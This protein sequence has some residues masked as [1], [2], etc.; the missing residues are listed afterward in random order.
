[1]HHYNAEA[2][3]ECF[4]MLDGRKA[5]GIDGV[6]KEEYQECL[7]QNLEDY[8]QVKANVISTRTRKTGLYSQGREAGANATIG[9]Q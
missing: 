6:C 7:K 4:D 8:N 9:Y 2:L 1:M 3:K 5:V